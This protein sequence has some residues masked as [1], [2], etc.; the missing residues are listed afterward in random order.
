LNPP[1]HTGQEGGRFDDEIGGKREEEEGY[2]CNTH[3]RHARISLGAVKK[4][5]KRDVHRGS[6]KGNIKDQSKGATVQAK[7]SISK[8]PRE[9]ELGNLRRSSF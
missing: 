3:C 1:G 7:G 8:R 9:Q 4:R 2:S 6:S 5:K